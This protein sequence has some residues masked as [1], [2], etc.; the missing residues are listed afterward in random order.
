[1]KRKGLRKGAPGEALVAPGEGRRGQ[2]GHIGYLLRQAQGAFRQAGDAAL[3]ETGLTLP[4]Y[5]VLSWLVIQ[6]PL[7]GAELA[8]LSMQT[9]QTLDLVIKN[10]AR[11]GLVARTPDPVHG[12]I[13][14]VSLTDEGRRRAAAAKRRI[15]ALED[16][17]VADLGAED[18]RVI[19]A[20]LAAVARNLLLRQ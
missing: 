13:L 19:R 12:R 17:L 4:Q 7:S 20:W 3:A 8:R 14:R 6:G 15:D 11:G 1:M 16:R 9:P 5:G 10:L 2:E 18:Q